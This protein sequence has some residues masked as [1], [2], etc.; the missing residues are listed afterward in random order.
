[1]GSGRS[2]PLL[3]EMLNDGLV[4]IDGVEYGRMRTNSSEEEGWAT[5]LVED[6][7]ELRGV[8][9]EMRKHT[10][11]PNTILDKKLSKGIRCQS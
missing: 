7:I 8:S 10:K 2:D 11:T 3:S 5:T 6:V 1:M 4:G 9:I